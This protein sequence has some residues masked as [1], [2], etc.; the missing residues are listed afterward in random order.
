MADVDQRERMRPDDLK[1]AGPACGA[2]AVAHRGFDRGSIL[3]WPDAPEP[4]QEQG[5]G[6]GGIVELKG[7]RQTRFQFDLPRKNAIHSLCRDRG[8]FKITPILR[9]EQ[10]VALDAAH[11]RQRAAH[12]REMAQSGD[13]VRLS[14][15]LL[16]VALDLDAEAEAMEI[17]SSTERRRASRTH[18]R[19]VYGA[20]LHVTD[21]R[22]DPAPVQIRNLSIGGAKFRTDN[23]PTPGSRVILELPARTLRLDGTIVRARGV[24]AAMVFDPASSADPALGR[25]LISETVADRVRA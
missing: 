5:C 16:E 6:D 24:D 17:N 2:Q 19:A 22:T 23:V 7:A 4:A 18:G 12:A 11:F 25:L 10:E 20:L 1:A 21:S 8:R 9:K 13:D 14:R 3:R 15:M